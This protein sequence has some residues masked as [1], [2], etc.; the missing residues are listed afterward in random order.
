MRIV[1]VVGASS[2]NREAGAIPAAKRVRRGIA[3]AS[4][5][6]RAVLFLLLQLPHTGVFA[7]FGQQADMVT[8][9]GQLAVF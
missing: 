2:I 5:L 3:L 1:I 4:L 6:D 7:S 9:L 8:L